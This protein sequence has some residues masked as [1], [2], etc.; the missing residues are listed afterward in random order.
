[1]TAYSWSAATVSFVPDPAGVWYL[2]V[3]PGPAHLGPLVV[4]TLSPVAA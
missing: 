3:V 2:H 1:M 4:W